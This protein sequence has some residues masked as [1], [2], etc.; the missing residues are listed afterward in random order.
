MEEEDTNWELGLALETSFQDEEGPSLERVLEI[1]KGRRIPS[2]LRAQVWQ[3]CFGVDEYTAKLPVGSDIYDLKEQQELRAD[4]QKFVEKF[5]NEE[6]DRVSITSD[7]ES[8][9]TGYCK[10]T[11]IHYEVG[12]G[13]LEVLQPLVTL[14][15]SAGQLYQCFRA[16]MRDYVPRDVNNPDG[17]PFHIFRLLL[18]YH[19]PQ[20]CSLLDSKRITPFLYCSS[21]FRSL[22]TSSCNSEA[23]LALWDI[24]LQFR[25][26]F[27]I[28][29]MGLALVI[30]AKEQVI[31]IHGSDKEKTIELLQTL[32]NSLDPGDITD[33]IAISQHY[34]TATPYSYRKM[35][36]TA[37][38]GSESFLTFGGT[39]STSPSRRVAM[40]SLCMPISAE[41]LLH[42]IRMARSV[43]L[44][45]EAGNSEYSVR[46][47]VVDCR[48]ADQY[49]AGHLPTAFHLDCGLMLQEPVSFSTAV[50]GL[51]LAQKEALSV[52]ST[53][54]G[55]H[56]CFVGSGREEEDQYVHMVVSSFL[57][58]TTQKVGLLSGGYQALHEM[59]SPDPD[60]G[61]TDHDS[62]LCLEC[63][64][65]NATA[66]SVRDSTSPDDRATQ[67]KGGLSM[68][69]KSLLNSFSNTFKA[70]TAGM[71]EKI[72]DYIVNPIN[73]PDERHVKST[74]K[75][76]S[77]PYR[78]LASVFSL[79][80]VDEPHPMPEEG[81]GEQI[82]IK[83]W[84]KKPE[85]LGNFPCSEVMAN[86][87]HY[88]G[89][90]VVT[91]TKIF[92]LR[93]T[94]QRDIGELSVCRLLS[95]VIKITS[96]KKHPELITF[97]Y[98]CSEGDSVLITHCDRFYLPT[99][100]K[101]FVALVK[102][103]IDARMAE[104]NQ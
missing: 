62:L 90:V 45:L 88:V 16:V 46:F 42:S 56:L 51:L 26:P 19:D 102:K 85:V 29:Q 81:V 63:K 76:K 3:L 72:K 47:F 91:A 13:W 20:L 75:E 55:E 92:M 64:T 95:S 33:F 6:E 35:F 28:F 61:L 37:L 100:S 50:Q 23:A 8:V 41:E 69:S 38:F 86:G 44:Q 10:S 4:C 2:H 71:K 1:C 99:N 70:K 98:G 79:D 22:F 14:K 12:C 67:S 57:Q 59:L 83:T 94:D 27:L 48:P 52:G 53:A 80:P 87:D 32:P 60:E 18:L 78:N 103:Q 7:L 36:E 25:D 97:K 93:E 96:K 34:A 104:D 73:T 74:D 31:E 9:L 84:L 82:S 65:N 15:V 21:W 11:G 39:G 40:H 30:N 89:F 68:T 58:R 77:K 66:Q 49:N 24:Y 54:G 5:G 43:S 101:E 17:L